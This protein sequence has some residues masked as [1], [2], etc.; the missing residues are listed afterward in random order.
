MDVERLVFPPIPASWVIYFFY[1]LLHAALPRVR[2]AGPGQP[3]SSALLC[4]LLACAAQ[5]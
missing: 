1:R 2:Q 3:G 4:H 5:R